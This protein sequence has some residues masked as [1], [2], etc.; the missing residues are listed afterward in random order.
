MRVPIA[1]LALALA[2]VP[3]SAFAS[4]DLIDPTDA[5]P[6]HPG[7]TYLDLV[8]QSVPDL[9]YNDAYKVWQGHLAHSLRH[10][11]GRASDVDAP[12]PVTLS[13][14]FDKRIHVGGRSRIVLSVDFGYPEDTVESFT[15]LALYDDTATTPRLLDAV[16]IGLDKDTSFDEQA[17]VP[18]GPGDDA[19]G[20][21]SEH[22]NSNQTYSARLLI[23]PFRD[24]FQ[25]I[26]NLFTLSEHAC[27]Y[28]HDEIPTVATRAVRGSPYR[29]V[30]LTVADALIHNGED[31]GDE[32]IPRPFHHAWHATYLWN[33]VR[34]VYVGEERGLAPL[35]K[36][37]Q[38]EF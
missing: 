27:G 1:A 37:N 38:A 31:C 10:A 29:E 7:V 13:F 16:D 24:H 4:P 14:I 11:A 34:R 15:M 18:L 9:A 2:A 3:V 5:V 25:T 32:A 35:D 8:K 33:A 17:I 6:G 28:E 30:L 23:F 26:A 36:E 19:I 12:D 20:T 22:F 21:Y